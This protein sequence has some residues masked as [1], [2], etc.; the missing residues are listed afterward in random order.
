MKNTKHNT[1][2]TVTAL[3][4]TIATL[5]GLPATAEAAPAGKSVT[6]PEVSPDMLNAMRRD[7]KGT[8]EQLMRRLDFEAKAP[9]L[10][11]GLREQLGDS[12]GGA[13]LNEKGTQLI[14]GVTDEA[15][16]AR[17]RRAG[18]E[19]RLVKHNK[20]RLDQIMEELNRNAHNA[21]SS[22][23]AWYVDV[24]TNSVVVLAENAT[25][26]TAS[27]AQAFAA[28]S[29]GAKDGALRVEHSA[30]AP[31]PAYDVRG[32]EVYFTGT[33][34]GGSYS[35]CSVG[36]SVHGGFVTA[37]HCGGA[38]TPTLGH[39]WQS[40]GTV[41]ASVWPGND[42]AWVAT[43]S[44]WTP[45]PWVYNHNNGNVLVQGSNPASIGASICRSGNTTGWRCGTLLATNVTVN[46]SDGP[47]YGLSTTD[48][49]AD[50]GDS[51]GAVLSGNQAQGVTSGIAGGCANGN[52][53]RT[54][55][56]PVNPIL[57]AYGLS[58]VTSG[59]GGST[60]AFVSRMNGKCIDVPN[61]NFSDGVQLQM[62]TCNGTNA[63]RFTWDGARLKIGGKCMDVSG[64]S[65]ANGTRIQLANCNGNRAQDFTLSPAGDLV[66]YLAD[67]CVDIEGFNGND[68]AKLSIYT[69]SGTSNQKWDF[70]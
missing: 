62:Y 20:A 10:E 55:F 32:G 33:G 43:N 25:S 35:A 24:A 63:Q 21:P 47:V 40:M 15:S 54:F 69:C 37:G 6:A 36:F 27:R 19:P 13:W 29:S 46:Y 61:A 59:G 12:F 1:L 38:G 3:F 17:V 68:G 56:Q 50:P 14:I 22:V 8:E 66:S 2:S 48:A 5:N 39:N 52:P 30:Q 53:P 67:K 60:G 57:N 23:H 4:A 65:T 28:L 11:R 64:A 41:R 34:A 9:S 7:L 26:L 44:S 16:A 42:W 31:R 70:R 58:L 45:Q 51:G 49:C 18:A